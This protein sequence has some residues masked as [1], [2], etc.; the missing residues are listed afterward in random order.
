VNYGNALDLNVTSFAPL[1][2]FTGSANVRYTVAM[3][4]PDAPTPQ[5]PTSAQIRHWLVTDVQASTAPTN[6]SSG[7]VLSGYRA[8]SP[9][10]GSAPHRYAFFL[11]QQPAGANITLG[12]QS[13]I[14]NFNL[15]AFITLNRLTVVSGNYF[16][17][18]RT[19]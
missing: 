15:A 16:N 8:P 17:A 6:I 12:N 18:S 19:N 1:I 2:N 7:N 14:Q 10:A 9:P 3:V 13:A 4:D 5:N 11:L